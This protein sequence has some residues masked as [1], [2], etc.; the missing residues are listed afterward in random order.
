MVVFV[1]LL[2]Y[3]RFFAGFV[4]VLPDDRSVTIMV[5]TGSDGYA[6]STGANADADADLFGKRRSREAKGGNGTNH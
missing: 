3:H 6:G 1:F 5:M 2:D 4:P